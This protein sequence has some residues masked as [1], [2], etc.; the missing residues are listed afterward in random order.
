MSIQVV[1]DVSVFQSWCVCALTQLCPTLCDPLDCSLAGSLSMGFSQQE[2]WRRLPCPPPGEHLDQELNLS[3]LRLPCCRRILYRWATRW[4]WLSCVWFFVTPWTV[5]CQAPLFMEYWS[6]LPFS[7]PG[8][9][10]DPEIEPGSPSLQ[11]DSLPPEPSGNPQK[12]C[13][14]VVK[15]Q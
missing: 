2:Y 5:A 8:D 12:L 4:K 14:Y 6:G 10:P 13:L 7:S 9:L 1:I 15:C 11:G 3:P